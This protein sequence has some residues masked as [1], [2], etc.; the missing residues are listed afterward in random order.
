MSS[1]HNTHVYSTSKLVLWQLGMSPG[2]VEGVLVAWG[3]H[4]RQQPRLIIVEATVRYMLGKDCF[5]TVVKDYDSGKIFVHVRNFEQ[6]KRLGSVTVFVGGDSIIFIHVD[7][8]NVISQPS[9]TSPLGE[10]S[11][12][13]H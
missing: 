9:D 8:L 4:V 11:S 7:R 3:C 13:R 5:V 2:I 1:Y 12:F 6:M 10:M